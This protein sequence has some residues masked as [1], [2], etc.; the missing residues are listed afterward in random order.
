MTLAI[1]WRMSMARYALLF[2]AA[3]LPLS[4]SD[5]SAATIRCP[6][7]MRLSIPG[8]GDGFVQMGHD[9][10]HG[11]KRKPRVNMFGVGPDAGGLEQVPGAAEVLAALQDDVALAGAPVRR[12]M[13]VSWR[14]SPRWNTRWTTV[15]SPRS[16]LT[17]SPKARASPGR[18]S[19]FYFSS[20]DAVLMTL[21]ER[22]IAKSD[23]TFD[24]RADDY[25]GDPATAWRDCI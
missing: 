4:A 20:K 23:A 6:R 12:G 2:V 21:P 9:R 25:G 16:P 18:L 8:L 13:T 3:Q 17:T 7:R 5:Q 1:V 24:G 11:L 22:V 19:T 15:R 14:F 10:V